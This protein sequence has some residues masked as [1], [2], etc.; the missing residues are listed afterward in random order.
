MSIPDEARY[1]A[2]KRVTE[3]YTGK[4][5]HGETVKAPDV[6]DYWHSQ[7]SCYGAYA[8]A[9]DPKLREEIDKLFLDHGAALEKIASWDYCKLIEA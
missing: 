2:L 4:N 3:Y 5:Q 8:I 9:H 6:A 1:F 7:R